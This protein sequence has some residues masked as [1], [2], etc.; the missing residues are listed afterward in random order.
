MTQAVIDA[1]SASLSTQPDNHDVRLHLTRLLLEARR[2]AEA[3]AHAQQVLAARPTHIETLYLASWAADDAGQ[4]DLAGA[5]RQL[6]DAL[7]GQAAAGSDAAAPA[8]PPVQ[9]AKLN[10]EPE[11][12]QVQAQAEPEPEIGWEVSV[13]D[14]KLSDVAGMAAVKRRLDLSL[15][16]P[17][18]HPEL[19]QMYGKSLRGGLLM[20]GPPGCGKTFIARALAGELGASF[21]A[22]GLNDVLDMWMG[23]SEKNVHAMFETA[24]RRAPCVL[25]LDELD[26]LGRKR[27]QTRSGG[28]NVVNQLLMELD[29]IQERAND[30]VYVL[31]A[32][33]SPWDVDP[34]LRRPG[35]F[36]RTVLVLPPDEPAR[37][38]TLAHHLK[39]RPAAQLDLRAVAARTERYSGAD[40]AHLIDSAAEHA[41]ED[42]VRTGQARPIR[43]PDLHQALREVR[44][45]TDAW[46]QTARN[47]VLFA[48]SDGS[49]DELRDYMRAQKLL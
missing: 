7:S 26:A 1:L 49:Y 23:N 44:P 8:S 36:D 10:P 27:S 19:R 17:L 46:F 37:E 43:A 40:L 39:G 21:L 38:A 41:I 12:V 22:V 6:H 31:A 45:S 13:S 32:T 2:P 18:R 20:Y 48:N 34:A 29:G 3:L 28:A 14:L 11:R 25:F 9:V 35:R 4:A 5:Y 30:G 24:R 42:A 47:V 16:A 33:N 15:L